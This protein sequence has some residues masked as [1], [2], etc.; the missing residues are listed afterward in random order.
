MSVATATGTL[1]VGEVAQQ[2]GEVPH[3]STATRF[4]QGSR[5][6]RRFSSCRLFGRGAKSCLSVCTERRVAQG[7]ALPLRARRMAPTN[8]RTHS[9]RIAGPMSRRRRQSRISPQARLARGS[10]VSMPH[11]D[12]A[13]WGLSL[14]LSAGSIQKEKPRRSGFP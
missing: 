1:L 5:S 12:S 14:C 11:D 9:L 3:S 13:P 8:S 6:G 2:C 10:S 4:V 7:T